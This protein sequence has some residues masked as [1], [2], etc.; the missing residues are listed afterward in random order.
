MPNNY[1]DLLAEL[2]ELV[3]ELAPEHPPDRVSPVDADLVDD[4][5]FHSVALVELGFAV[6]ERYGLDPIT[7][8]EVEGVRTA[9]DLTRFVAGRLALEPSEPT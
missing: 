4:L 5:G 7:P 2:A 1:Q 3:I 6:E 9:A 8:E